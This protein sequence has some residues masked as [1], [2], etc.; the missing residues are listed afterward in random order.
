MN[1]TTRREAIVTGGQGLAALALGVIAIPTGAN[2]ETPFQKEKSMS[3]QPPQPFL[4][5]D[6][7]RA[8]YGLGLPGAFHRRLEP[9]IGDWNVEMTVFAKPDPI[10][11]E[12]MTARREWIMGK[13]HIKEEL[14]GGTISG[15]PYGRLTLLG[16]NSVNQ[17]YE[18]TSVDNMDTQN[19][20]YEGEAD[21]GG[22]VV[23]LHGVYTQAVYSSQVGGDGVSRATGGANPTPHKTLAGVQYAVRSVLTIE[24]EMKHLHQFYFH[25]ATGEEALAFQ[26][27]YKRR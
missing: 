9:L 18:L 25:P 2:A 7:Q 22:K 27:V 19:Q 11:S 14:L 1:E 3:E 5:A 8:L 24:S 6:E 15:I 26:F 13:R 16:Y 23:T 20:R 12:G 4:T 17:R 10:V 21:T